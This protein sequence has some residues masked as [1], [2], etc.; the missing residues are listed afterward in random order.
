MTQD[1]SSDQLRLNK[2]NISEI[3]VGDILAMGVSDNPEADVSNASA[4]TYVRTGEI[5]QKTQSGVLVDF[6]YPSADIRVVSI[7]NR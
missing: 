6:G 4:I 7:N 1:W 3:S 5:T 2:V